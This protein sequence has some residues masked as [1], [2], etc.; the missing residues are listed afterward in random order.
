MSPHLE[1]EPSA[2]PGR[3]WP[4]RLAALA[5]ALG[6]GGTC[7]LLLG[8]F[9]SA[10]LELER[11]RAGDVVGLEG[12]PVHVSLPLGG[13]AEPSTLRVL[14]NGADVTRQ[15]G[16]ASNGAAG[17]LHGLLPGENRLRVEVFGRSRWGP[18]EL[19][20]EE[21]RE[22]EVLYRPPLDSDRG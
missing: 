6:C 14:L 20:I 19:W 12:L 8:F 17:R 16:P 4:V 3:A 11:P 13:R 22:V 1:K 7:A 9:G 10:L 21:A 18:R 15:L 5:L 2:P